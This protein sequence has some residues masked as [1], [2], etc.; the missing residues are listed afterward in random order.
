MSDHTTIEWTDATW[1]P[2]TGC[3]KVSAGCDHCYAETF[4]ERFRGT[5]GHYF[6]N[7]F[8]VQL[9]ENKLTEPLRWRKPRKVFVNSMSDLF[10]DAVPDWFIAH[11]FGVMALAPQHTFQILTKRHA[12]MRSLL[13]A[14]KVGNWPH[15]FESMVRNAAHNTR[16]NF[17]RADWPD[18]DTVTWPLPNVW[19]GVSTENQQWAD[20]RI[21]ALLDTPAAVRFIS[22]EPLLGPMQLR[23]EWGYGPGIDWLI[24]GGESGRGA[25]PM[26]PDWARALRDHRDVVGAAFLFKQW[27]EWA[28]RGPDDPTG[29][30]ADVF[31]DRDGRGTYFAN[32]YRAD[33]QRLVRVGKKAAGRELDGRTWDEFPGGDR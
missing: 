12:R 31:L 33:V 17:G 21:P 1:N 15:P 6:E 23:R 13:S 22:A 10:H 2:V 7:G 32:R 24:V 29:E 14:Q 25:R 8:D 19:L 18:A 26:H 30:R 27:G 28:P 16:N 5:P 3:T 9:R 11:V 20:I 4:A